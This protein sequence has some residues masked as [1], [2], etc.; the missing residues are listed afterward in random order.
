[1]HYI[2]SKMTQSVSYT[3]WATVDGVPIA[4]EQITIQGGA[5]IPSLRSGFGNQSSNAEGRPIW[6]AD[7]VLTK[8][9]ENQ[10]AVL[11]DHPV[12]KKH[13]KSGLLQVVSRDISRNHSEVARA[14]RD[15]IGDSF[16]ILSKDTLK[17]KI[18]VTTATAEQQ[19][20]IRF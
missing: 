7:G 6:T 17:Q 20:G 3:N 14:A 10:Y 9:G 16:Q 8:V 15:M 13:L 19:D 11:K 5:G 12:F 2:L 18:K 4:K 1:M